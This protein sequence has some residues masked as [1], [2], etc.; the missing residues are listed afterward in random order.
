MNYDVSSKINKLKQYNYV[1]TI[2]ILFAISLLNEYFLDGMLVF[3]YVSD[4][5]KF[6][7]KVIDLFV[8]SIALGLVLIQKYSKRN[9]I[10]IIAGYIL[11]IS[12]FFSTG[13]IGLITLWTWIILTI[14]VPYDKWVKVSLYCHSIGIAT[15]ILAT[16]V[17]IYHDLPSTYRSVLG[18]RYTFGLGQ[19]NFTGNILFLIVV[20]YWWLRRDKLKKLDYLFLIFTTVIIYVFMNS[21][22][23]TVVLMVF[24]FIN[25]FFQQKIEDNKV[26]SI[27]LLVLFYISILIAGTSIIL[28]IINVAEIPW[29]SYVDKLISYRFSDA[30]RTF[31]IYG[32]S[33]FGQRID[34]SI[35]N[36]QFCFGGDR[37]FYMDCMWIYFP[38]HY[39]IVFSAIFIYF[40]FSSMYIFVKRGE[41]IA[42]SIFFCGTL[43]AMEQ[44]IWPYL[45][46]WPFMIFLAEML[47]KKDYSCPLINKSRKLSVGEN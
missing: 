15:G 34:F 27:G 11:M 3:I 1:K 8:Y 45:F 19:P 22:G 29:L 39:G 2:E 46:S 4:W 13:E 7:S 18:I 41:V 32:F 10:I 14:Q 23:T 5:M 36:S 33:L 31:K 43:Y 35:L 37:N 30:Y 20:S 42:V 47:F 24:I 6:F 28:C 38:V 9:I 12:G 44:R 26:R 25:F 21:L 16:I 40:Y 17:G